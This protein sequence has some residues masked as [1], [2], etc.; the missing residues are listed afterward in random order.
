VAAVVM[1]AIVAVLAFGL[2]L[3][4]LR[5]GEEAAAQAG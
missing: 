5:R 2:M 4:R 3:M 1:T